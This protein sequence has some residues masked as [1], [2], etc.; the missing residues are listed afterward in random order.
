MVFEVSASYVIILPVMIANTTAYLISRA[1][2]PM[3]FFKMLA[4]LEGVNL[5]TA[6]EKRS[7]QPFRVEDAMTPTASPV[8]PGVKLFPDETLDAALR[9]LAVQPEI[10]VV[11]RL[12]SEKVLGVLT[13]NDV[14]KAYGLTREK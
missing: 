5:P 7:L 12:Q 14:Y 10:Q 9:L 6:E 3:P 4:Q 13:L 8:K 2:H 11:S 1:L